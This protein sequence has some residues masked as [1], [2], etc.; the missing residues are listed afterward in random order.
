[1]AEHASDNVLNVPVQ[2]QGHKPSYATTNKLQ[3]VVYAVHG[4][5]TAGLGSQVMTAPRLCTLMS[6]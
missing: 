5:L 2:R 3:L 4:T 6:A 1:M